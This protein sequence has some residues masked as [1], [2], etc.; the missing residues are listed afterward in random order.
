M[1]SP[2]PQQQQQARPAYGPVPWSRILLFV[3]CALFVIAAL[4]AG[5]VVTWDA[6]A[7]G[8]GGFAAWALSGAV[9]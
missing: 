9:P 4:C 1:T 7:F 5:E 8:F 6:W 3:A 2:A